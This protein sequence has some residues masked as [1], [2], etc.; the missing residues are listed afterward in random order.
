MTLEIAYRTRLGTAAGD[1]QQTKSAELD[2]VREQLRV[3]R[4]AQSTAR[5]RTPLAAQLVARIRDLT[6]RETA[7]STTLT[8]AGSA[9]E[10]GMTSMGLMSAALIEADSATRQDLTFAVAERGY[11]SRDVLEVTIVDV[12]SG[13]GRTFTG[14]GDGRTGAGRPGAWEAALDDLRANL[15]R[16]RGWLA[17][18]A[19][20][21]YANVR[22]DVPNP[23][24][25]RL[26]VTDQL[27]E[28]VDDAAHAATLIAVLAAPFTEGASLGILGV[29]APVQAATTAYHLVDRARYG[30]L[31]LDEDAIMGM[32][33]IAT[34]GLGHVGQVRSASRGLQMV[35][36]ASRVAVRL[37][38]EGQIRGDDLQR[39]PR[40]P[41]NQCPRRGRAD[42]PPAPAD[43]PAGISQAAGITAASHAF[44]GRG[45]LEIPGERSRPADADVGGPNSQTSP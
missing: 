2:W 13:S 9:V 35:A 3:L 45:H 41:D 36:N 17:W 27:V 31:R 42:Q 16:G 38:D 32:I 30:D 15:N 26:S 14:S 23:M 7:L 28:T 43:C 33:N 34:V 25:L 24:Q 10:P 6:A 19:P 44:G 8:A 11:V 20:S 5:P 39:L 1:T 12:T 21:A 37:L 40:A 4:T 22:V 29:I 18:R